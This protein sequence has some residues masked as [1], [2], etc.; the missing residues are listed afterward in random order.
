MP[1]LRRY[2][3]LLLTLLS[4][5]LQAQQY[6][7][8]IQVFVTPPYPQ[9]LRGY[10][11]TF[12]QKIQAHFLLKD[13]STAGR[14]F[15]LRFSLENFQG[16]TIAQTPDYITPYLVNLS[17]GVRRTL[18][19][20]DFKSLLR[21]ENLYG[22]NEATYNG[23]LPE[24]TYFIGLSLYDVATGRPVS[25]KGRAMIQVRRYSPPVLTMPQK[26]EVL[27]KKNAFQNILFQWMPRDIAPFM[28]YE[29]TLKEVWDLALV[30]EEAF[31]SGRLVYQTKT[32]APAL[33]YT[34]M[35]PI[36][37]ENK[38]YVW[39]VRALTN[40]P[41]NPN[42]QSY[43]RN[44]GN[45]ETFYFDLV[46]NCEAPR[47]LTAMTEST[48]AQLR[49]SAQAMMP[50]Q[51]YPYKVMYR[52][53]GKSWKSQKVS[54]PYAKVI[55][56]KRG[57]TYIYKVGVACGLNAA[58]ST[59]VFGEDSY[60]YSTEQEFTTT[61]Q[62]DEKSQV[63]CGVKPEIRIKNTEPLQDNLYPNTTFRA[64][65]F[66]VTVLN[67]T[68]SNGIYSGEGYVKVPYLQDTKI[69]VVFNGIKLN[70]ERQ[71]IDG[72]LVTTYDE[73]ERNVVEVPIIK[74]LNK[75]FDVN[76][77]IDEIYK[78]G[79]LTAKEKD[80]L[81]KK[82]EEL[83]EIRTKIEQQPSLTEE[84]KDFAESLKENEQNINNFLSETQSNTT[85]DTKIPDTLITSQEKV[86]NNIQV[87]IVSSGGE[88]LELEENVFVPSYS[89]V[90]LKIANVNSIV[91][92]N[93]GAITTIVTKENK[94]YQATTYQGRFFGYFPKKDLDSL[95]NDNKL[96]LTNELNKFLDK[97]KFKDYSVAQKGDKVFTVS[98]R[99][100]GKG[101]A[102]DCLCEFHWEEQNTRNSL[103]IKVNT[104]KS[105]V[106]LGAKSRN[107][108]GVAC[109]TDVK[110]ALG[111]IL[112]VALTNNTN[113]KTLW[114][115]K[116]NLKKLEQLQHYLDDKTEGK[117]YALYDTDYL[118][119]IGAKSNSQ[120][121]KYFEKNRIF[122]LETFKKHFPYE[123][124][125]RDVS[126]IL[127]EVDLRKEIPSNYNQNSQDFHRKGKKYEYS[128][129]DLVIR[130]E[131]L[132]L[133]E[134]DN[135]KSIF[136]SN[137]ITRIIYK[138]E[139]E[140]TA[141][142]ISIPDGCEQY[143]A[144]YGTKSAVFFWMG[145]FS[146]IALMP[147]AQ[148]AQRLAT[149]VFN[150]VKA[151]KRF[152]KE[153]IQVKRILSEAF[154]KWSKNST[155]FDISL[156]NKQRK[157][158]EELGFSVENTKKLPIEIDD[159]KNIGK[160]TNITQRVAN[161]AN[162]TLDGKLK[163]IADAWKKYYPD[164]F[165]ERKFFEDLMANYRYKTTDG[166]ARTSNIAEN[167]KGVD[168]YKDFTEVG[169]DIYA[170]TAVSMKTTI[171][172][173]VENWLN[174]NKNHI[175]FIANSKGTQAGKGITWNG[176]NL[177]YE[178]GELHIYIPK[179]YFNSE[180]KSEWINTLSKYNPNI[181]YE[182]N[183]LENYLK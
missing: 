133:L 145:N 28:Q 177:F 2:I 23:L 163:E 139:S 114:Q 134:K 174:S 183:T 81:K 172:K 9:S 75:L 64:G 43:F 27:T 62:I 21:Y 179:E 162:K 141:M 73:T 137:T 170:K 17:P 19:N 99:I 178:K 66:P 29:F 51:E 25:N 157:L 24:G 175:D 168:F 100:E 102:L 107:C 11:D 109:K 129:S 71:L 40:N 80:I 54:M 14:P 119:H 45:S 105:V 60:V 167:F 65:D 165:A 67:A 16:Q 76:S 126:I 94:H 92:D 47:M 26:G 176:K 112:F 130:Y 116:A 61:E 169:N 161:F 180:L 44:N 70:T 115:E 98:K 131:Y 90:P 153:S 34:N 106:P 86:K 135:E 128:F 63:Q 1:L 111:S 12:E 140:G 125:S 118:K 147:Q 164:V 149:S 182:I 69:K 108:K 113:L 18:T 31:M 103:E 156:A 181:K 50:N 138:N 151:L 166:W 22:I 37:L 7:V 132:Y 173:N 33:Q 158:W 74:T 4:F 122:D 127:S 82:V 93:R 3:L 143:I 59:S 48:S 6:P 8:D 68:G 39:Q 10:A 36:L 136:D 77:S 171:V 38:R 110:N 144:L 148:Y 88:S 58:N 146:E 55:G 123:N 89:G 142:P 117:E 152:T 85:K 57:R 32:N 87:T 83:A 79:E 13:L 154:K 52:E 160:E 159:L 124:Y 72:K 104:D 35:M 96:L 78:D 49:W 30:P 53:R 46:S 120:Y 15:A 42:E 84:E 20:I 5:T 121:I 41:A 97:E 101:I 150:N 56:L 155:S 95:R 91:L